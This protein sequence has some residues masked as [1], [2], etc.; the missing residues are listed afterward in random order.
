MSALYAV[1]QLALMLV[2][3]YVARAYERFHVR[4]ALERGL[5]VSKRVDV[6]ADDVWPKGFDPDA[7][8]GTEHSVTVTN[9]QGAELVLRVRGGA[10]RVVS[11]TRPV[12]HESQ[13]GAGDTT[14]MWIS[15][16]EF[17][18]KVRRPWVK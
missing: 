2:V 1:G 16:D 13:L 9:G 12:Q 10:F 6:P 11:F 14:D 8:L 3:W 4:V 17:V 7:R 18:G 5:L 15:I